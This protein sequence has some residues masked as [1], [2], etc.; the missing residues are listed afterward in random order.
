MRWMVW[1]WVWLVR[2]L[3]MGELPEVEED[4]LATRRRRRQLAGLGSPYH[5]R[6]RR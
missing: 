2:A 4:Q 3:G 6:G 1:L 5:Q